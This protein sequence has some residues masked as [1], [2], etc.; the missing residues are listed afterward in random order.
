MLGRDLLID[1]GREEDAKIFSELISGIEGLMEEREKRLELLE[2][3]KIEG[4]SV[5]VFELYREII[6]ISKKLRDP[7]SASFY[8]SELI[9]YF[10]NSLNFIDLEKYRYEL[11]QKAELITKNNQFE[12]AAELYGKCEKISQLFIQLERD[13]EVRNFEKYKHK[14]TECL[15]RVKEKKF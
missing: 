14:K 6:G 10:Q 11:N 2:Q 7:D 9:N 3:V 1:L 15:N 12:I 13:G 5:E 4:N 8:Q